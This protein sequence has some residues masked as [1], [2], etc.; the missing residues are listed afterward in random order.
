M[1]KIRAFIAIS[2][3]E[4]LEAGLQFVILGY[5]ASLPAEWVKW[6]AP[7]NMHLTLKFLG[8]IP[9]SLVPP[10]CSK[11]D[12]LAETQAGF[13]LQA[14]GA[15]MFPSAARPRVIWVGLGQSRPLVELA[16]RLDQSL[17]ALRIPVEERPF[18]PHLTI[19]RVAERLDGADLRELGSIVLRD[20]PGLIASQDVNGFSLYRSELR[21]EGAVHT[22]LHTASFQVT[23]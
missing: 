15:G 9:E 21:R 13:T 22:C 2:L 5:R 14:Q 3:G 1:K 4:D 12:I 19:G 10:I 11:M 8:D 16:S 6:S 23:G 17:S 7:A 18:S 20:K